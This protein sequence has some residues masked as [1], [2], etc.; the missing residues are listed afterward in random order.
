MCAH[1]HYFMEDVD[2]DYVILFDG[3][4]NERTGCPEELWAHGVLE[5]LCMHWKIGVIMNMN[6]IDIPKEYIMAGGCRW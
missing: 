6:V 1:L 2:S 5:E 3:K 4:R